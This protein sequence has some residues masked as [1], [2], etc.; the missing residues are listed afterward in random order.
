MNDER[1]EILQ[2]KVAEPTAGY[3][4][5][6]VERIRITNYRFFREAEDGLVLSNIKDP[7]NTC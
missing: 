1:L 7:E 3:G 2:Q 6:R 5:V 4:Q